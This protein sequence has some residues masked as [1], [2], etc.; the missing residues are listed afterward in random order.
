MKKFIYAFSESDRDIL[1][2]QGYTL[3]KADNTKKM[4]VFKA[5]YVNMDTNKKKFQKSCFFS[6]SSKETYPSLATAPK[7]ATI[8]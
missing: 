2:S 1:L 6:V 5:E 7:A 3:L 4:Y 8:P